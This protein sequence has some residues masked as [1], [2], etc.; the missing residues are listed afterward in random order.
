MGKLIRI[1]VVMMAL[2]F[3]ISTMALAADFYI[4]KDA[5]GKMSI[6]ETKPA[7]DKS[8]VKGPFKTKEEADKAMKAVS[9]QKPKLPDSGC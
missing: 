2:V 7:D 5:S 6:T 1:A 4:V 9:S 3:G 8:I